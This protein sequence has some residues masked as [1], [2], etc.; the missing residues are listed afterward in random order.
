MISKTI[1]KCRLCKSKELQV[2]LELGDQPPANSLRKNLS[3]SLEN[4]P[5]TL[6][7]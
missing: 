2:I 4:V 6:C 1:V 7:R 5:L 3:N